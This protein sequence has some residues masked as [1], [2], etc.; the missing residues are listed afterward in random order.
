MESMSLFMNDFATVFPYNWFQFYLL[1]IIFVL[2]F[3]SVLIMLLRAENREGRLDH[4]KSIMN[5]LA[6]VTAWFALSCVYLAINRVAMFST[7]F[8]IPYVFAQWVVLADP[9]SKP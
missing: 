1:V 3:F 7:L 8:L 9:S 4:Q 6:L 5:A 2:P